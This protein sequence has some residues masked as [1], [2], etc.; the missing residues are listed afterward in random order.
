[1]TSITKTKEI[2]SASGAEYKAPFTPN[3][4]GSKRIK[5]TL[6]T[7]SLNS[8][9]PIESV[10]LPR[11]CK[12]ILIAFCIQHNTIVPKYKRKARTANSFYKLFSLPKI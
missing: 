4:V 7:K 2:Q 5:G 12:N 8:D 3:M 11:D 9:S 1:M 10:G 6:N